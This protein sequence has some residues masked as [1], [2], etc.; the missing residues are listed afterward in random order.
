MS[1]QAPASGAPATEHPEDEAAVQAAVA[2]ALASGTPLTVRGGG[3]KAGLGRPAQAGI[4]LDLSKLSGITLYEPS[5]LVMSA[6]AGTPLADVVAAL[7]K[8]GQELAFEPMDYSV[9][10][11]GDGAKATIGAVAACNISGPRRILAGAARDSLIGVRFVNGRGEAIKSGGRV[12]KNVTGYDLVK[13]QAGAHGTLGVLTEVTFKVLPKAPASA[14]LVFEGLGD[15]AA[16]ALMS[17]A[18]G[19]PYEVNGAAHLPASDDAPARTALRIENVQASVEYRARALAETL[20]DYG[21]P[22]LV[23]GDPAATFWKGVRDA[24]PIAAPRDWA[25]WRI[26]TAPTDG[27]QLVAEIAGARETRHFYDWGGGLVWL[28]TPTADDAGAATIRAALAAHGA[29]GGHATLV[30]APDALR[31]SVDVFQPLDDPTRLITTR[32]KH[33]FD[34]HGLINP[35]RMYA[36][37]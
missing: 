10:L 14:T 11:G 4:T 22:H 3:T 17:A 9:L 2:R 15:E 34:P 18:L 33:E 13:L 19:S 36:G 37:I 30:R 8:E 35:G 25:V 26:S 32:L 20:S 23:T 6:K 7:D 1:D 16:R 24:A 21:K 29:R 31:A 12:M 27:P 5:E 28:A